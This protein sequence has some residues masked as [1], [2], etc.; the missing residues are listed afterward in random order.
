[1]QAVCTK[2]V[3]SVIKRY[4]LAKKK[5]ESNLSC[6]MELSPAAMEIEIVESEKCLE[7]E[8][9]TLLSMRPAEL[10]GVVLKAKLFIDEILSEAELT[11]FHRQAL[12]SIC[13]DLEA[14][15]QQETHKDLHFGDP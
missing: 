12:K 9:L 8:F 2:T 13:A 10:L 3:N 11:R 15:L 7:K 14:L 4:I 1:M 5:L 6:D